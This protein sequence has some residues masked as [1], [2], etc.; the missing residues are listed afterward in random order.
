MQV[1]NDKVPS[2]DLGAVL[3]TG[4]SGYIGSHTVLDLLEKGFEVISLDNFDNSHKW[5]NDRIKEVIAADYGEDALAL[6]DD[7]DYEHPNAVASD[8]RIFRL[9]DIIHRF[10]YYEVDICNKKKLK[11]IFEKHPNIQGI[12]HFAA[13]KAVGESCEKP[14]KYYQNNLLG[15]VNILAC[16]KKYKVPNF[17]FSSS[18]TVYGNA[19]ELPDR[20]TTPQQPA[21]SPYGATKVMGE[22]IVEDFIKA[23][24]QHR[25]VLLRYFNPAGAHPSGLL[26]ELPQNKPQNLVPVITA[27]AAGKMEKLTVYGND[28]DT[29]D[30]SC[31]RDYI[32]V[33]DLAEAHTLALLKSVNKDLSN[34]EIFNLGIGEGA[35]VLEAIAAFE[36]VSDL[37]LNYEIGPRR[38]GDVV[39]IYADFAKAKEQLGWSPQYNMEDIMQTAWAWEKRVG[40]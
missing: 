32:H 9:K 12:I 8:K 21:E 15:L 34:L 19:T 28:Y 27:V 16:A 40:E 26:G 13:H 18:C 31:I 1:T 39:A 22:R 36:K 33:C 5:I 3:V 7:L 29:R 4:G 24:P 23:Y 20:E 17:I 6:I 30:G 10:R 38:A 14:L 25:A 11:K 35:S 37:K 2:G